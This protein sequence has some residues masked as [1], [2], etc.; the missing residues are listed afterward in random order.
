M[1]A[2]YGLANMDTVYN[3]EKQYNIE[4]LSVTPIRGA[5]EI[6]QTSTLVTGQENGKSNHSSNIYIA[7]S[8]IYT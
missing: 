6:Q 7:H 3:S 4:N 1:Y 5:A 2:A 8:S